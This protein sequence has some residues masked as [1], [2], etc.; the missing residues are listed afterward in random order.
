MKKSIALEIRLGVCLPGKGY[1]G[2]GNGYHREQEY[3]PNGYNGELD[4]KVI[5]GRQYHIGE[6]C[7][8]C[9]TVF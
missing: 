5:L 1:L 3:Q 8:F 4:S 7:V 6:H 2:L 9:F